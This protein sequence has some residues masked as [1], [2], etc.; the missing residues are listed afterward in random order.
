MPLV[1]IFSWVE[2]IQTRKSSSHMQQ[3]H[4]NESQKIWDFWYQMRRDDYHG[5]QDCG[6]MLCWS[7]AERKNMIF[8]RMWLLWDTHHTEIE[9][10]LSFSEAWKEWGKGAKWREREMFMLSFY[11]NQ[12]HNK[13]PSNIHFF[14]TNSIPGRN[15]QC[16]GLNRRGRARLSHQPFL[17]VISDFFFV[18]NCFNF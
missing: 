6:W 14:S 17:P 11:A 13:Q 1:S 8:S 18:L 4:K 15:R 7:I 10:C 2:N 5:I 12:L 3:A 9:R 16:A